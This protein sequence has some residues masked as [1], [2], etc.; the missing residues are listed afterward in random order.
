MSATAK[1]TLAT[2][3]AISAGIIGYVHYKQ[4]TDREKLHEG[5]TK[6]SRILNLYN[7]F[8]RSSSR[9]RKTTKAES[10]EQL[11]PPETDRPNKTTEIGFG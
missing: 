9:Y 3:C 10:R 4:T 1:L 7:F 6:F 5:L 11:Q 8:S 2:S